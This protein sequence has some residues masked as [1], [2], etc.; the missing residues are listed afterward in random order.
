MDRELLG[1]TEHFG[2]KFEIFKAKS[3]CNQEFQNMPFSD[4][5]DPTG[6]SV[7]SPVRG[8]TFALLCLFVLAVPNNREEKTNAGN[9]TGGN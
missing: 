9:Y 6:Y 4:V 8:I 5:S 3:S 1:S 7:P 2:T